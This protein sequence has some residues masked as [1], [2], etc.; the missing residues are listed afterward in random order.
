MDLKEFLKFCLLKKR[1]IHHMF[2]NQILNY[3]KIDLFKKEDF[4]NKVFYKNNKS[5]SGLKKE[6]QK[7]WFNLK[8]LLQSYL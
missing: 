8:P 3:G 4:F 2:Q 7:F 6:N 5:Y 1:L